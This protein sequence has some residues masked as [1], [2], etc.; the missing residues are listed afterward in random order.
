M[1][2]ESNRLG[3]ARLG[4]ARLGSRSRSTRLDSARLGS[5]RLDW[6]WAGTGLLTWR[7]LRVR[8]VP[9]CKEPH[10]PGVY[11]I[12]TICYSVLDPGAAP[13]PSSDVARVAREVRR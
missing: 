2:L 1:G 7:A 5:A 4:S 11:R 9:R 12:W 6:D 10:V 8:H 13:G 3:S